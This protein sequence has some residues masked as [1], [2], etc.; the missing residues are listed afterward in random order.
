MAESALS[1]PESPTVPQPDSFVV[2]ASVIDALVSLALSSEIGKGVMIGF[3]V[4]A[5]VPLGVHMKVI[6]QDGQLVPNPAGGS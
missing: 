4:T 2:P 6:V 5:G 1:S 3:R